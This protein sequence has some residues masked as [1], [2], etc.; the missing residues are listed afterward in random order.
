MI[1]EDAAEVLDGVFRKGADFDTVADKLQG[2]LFARLDAEL[3]ADR[4]RKDDL[5]FG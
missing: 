3:V 5:T 2:K 1:L 4:L